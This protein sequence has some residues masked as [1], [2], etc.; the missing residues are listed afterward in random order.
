MKK[1]LVF[2]LIGVGFIFPAAGNSAG[3]AVE[4]P[5]NCLGYAYTPRAE[6]AMEDLS[7]F[8]G[9]LN[10][11]TSSI[12]FIKSALGVLLENRDMKGIDWKGPLG[13]VLLQQGQEDPWAIGVRLS[14]PRSYYREL[15]ES[16][17]LKSED[18]KEKI[19]VYTKQEKVFDTL[20]YQQATAEEKKKSKEFFKTEEKLL[21]VARRGDFAWV[22]P[23]SALI[24]SLKNYDLTD[25]EVF[26]QS[27]FTFLLRMEPLLKLAR[28]RIDKSL[29]AIISAVESSGRSPKGT[30][31]AYLDLYLNFARQVKTVALG[32]TADKK[33]VSI[34]KMV[35]AESGSGLGEF[36]RLQ[37]NGRLKL[38]RY[39]DPRAWL[40]FD[41]RVSHPRMLIRP[42][43]KLLQ[44]SEPLVAQLVP[45]P[46]QADI[47]DFQEASLENISSYLD[48][49]SG[50]LAAS[51][52]A[53][54]GGFFSYLALLEVKDRKSYR[55]YISQEMPA[56][57]KKFRK[58]YREMGVSYD[59]TGP[60]KPGGGEDIY[61]LKMTFD[62]D[63]F[64]R[65]KK[66]G[67]K[68]MKLINK[69]LQQPITSRLTLKDNIGITAASWG[70]ASRLPEVLARIDQGKG[71]FDLSLIAPC[72]RNSHGLIYISLNRYLDFMKEL[73]DHKK[74]AG[75]EKL[76]GIDLPILIC[77]KVRGETLTARTTI[78]LDN[79]KKI[80]A[81]FIA[82]DP[83]PAPPRPAAPVHGAGPLSP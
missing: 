56:T 78:T 17:T 83:P 32:L 30:I 53:S 12:F 41:S 29:P 47:S 66:R 58:I 62:P 44:A 10:L 46:D 79:I 40:I 42:Y 38:A 23:N 28:K 39:L 55:R 51:I 1:W 52:S 68:E 25:L 60:E 20:A 76:T 81:A 14:A 61:S 75:L 34:E 13:V 26:P 5:Q 2:T 31:R 82:E 54:T 33:A 45:A 80:K 64:P 15:A 48:N 57:L 69:L 35:T 21:I 3:K 67:A 8:A 71:G 9:E 74:L 43:K 63:K 22:S 4:L 7:D 6:E 37:K 72:R 59:F 19:R 65:N 18:K 27:D 36:L 16:F 50:E 49:L 11:P 70:G 73:L 24:S 77:W